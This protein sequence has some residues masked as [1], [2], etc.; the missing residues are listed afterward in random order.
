MGIGISSATGITSATGSETSTGS[1]KDSRGRRSPTVAKEPRLE[2][3]ELID[4][5]PAFEGQTAT[6]DFA[7]YNPH[8]SPVTEVVSIDRD[9]R[10]TVYK[11]ELNVEAGSIEVYE[12]PWDVRHDAGTHTM[13]LTLSGETKATDKLEVQ[14]RS[15]FKPTIDSIEASGPNEKRA[16]VSYTVKN[17]GSAPDSHTVM[18]YV[19]GEPHHKH[20]V[21]SGFEYYDVTGKKFTHTFEPDAECATVRVETESNSTEETYHAE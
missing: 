8:P 13:T 2:Q 9:G 21:R 1:A 4:T 20:R 15:P 6:I 5:T 17:K 11:E 18:V 19:D 12:A 10:E 14:G 16:T 7:V 3:V